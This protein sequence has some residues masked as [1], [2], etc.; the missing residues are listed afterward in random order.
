MGRVLD[1]AEAAPPTFWLRCS[2]REFAARPSISEALLGL[3]YREGRVRL[4]GPGFAVAFRRKGVDLMIQCCPDVLKAIAEDEAQLDRRKPELIRDSI[5]P[6]F[7]CM[8]PPP[9]D[10]HA[11][12]ISIAS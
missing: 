6:R 8:T 1:T 12:V 10:S 2:D 7:F 11:L 9:E 5:C 3:R 4:I